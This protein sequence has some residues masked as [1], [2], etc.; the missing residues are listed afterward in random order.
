MPGTKKSRRRGRNDPREV[1]RAPGAPG[2]YDDW[3]VAELRQ[4]AEQ[5]G[6]SGYSGK[7]KA[8]LVALLR[9]H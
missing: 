5:L 7:K 6:L 9:K 4:R 2:S 8:G 3:T 1:V